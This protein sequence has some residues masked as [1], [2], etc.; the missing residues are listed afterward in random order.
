M[1]DSAHTNSQN[2][3]WMHTLYSAAASPEELETFQAGTFKTWK[4]AKPQIRTWLV[5]SLEPAE[6]LLPCHLWWLAISKRSLFFY[7][8]TWSWF[9]GQKSI[10][11]GLMKSKNT[12]FWKE[13]CVTRVSWKYLLQQFKQCQDARINTIHGIQVVNSIN[14]HHKE[15]WWAGVWLGYR[16]LAS[17]HEALGLI[18]R[19]SKQQ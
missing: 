17:M 10:N 7:T 12:L 1:L 11:I 3:C 8:S 2:H 19:T 14:N 13:S 18:P 5:P 16:V 9:P 4:D 6:H 15:S